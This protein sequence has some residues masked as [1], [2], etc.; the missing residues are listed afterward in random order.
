MLK[1]PV[2]S[3]RR[4]WEG[5]IAFIKTHLSHGSCWNS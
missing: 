4:V 5:E 3:V 1:R 2:K